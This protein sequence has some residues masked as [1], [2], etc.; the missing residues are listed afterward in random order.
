VYHRSDWGVGPFGLNPFFSSDS[1]LKV[2][3]QLTVMGNPSLFEEVEE[4]LE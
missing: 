1:E 3:D 2:G 4:I